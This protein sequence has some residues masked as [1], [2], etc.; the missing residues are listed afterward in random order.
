[1]SQ[2]LPGAYLKQLSKLEETFSL[3]MSGYYLEILKYAYK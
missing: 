1:M 2:M 3:S